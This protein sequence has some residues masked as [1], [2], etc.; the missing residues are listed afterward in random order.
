MTFG[1]GT[2]VKINDKSEY[3]VLCKDCTGTQMEDT[4]APKSKIPKIKVRWITDCKPG[5]DSEDKDDLEDIDLGFVL[6]V[7]RR[8]CTIQPRKRKKKEV[9]FDCSKLPIHTDAKNYWL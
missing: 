8:D 5:Y 4:I 9:V 7:D 3:Y 2:I 6:T 1:V